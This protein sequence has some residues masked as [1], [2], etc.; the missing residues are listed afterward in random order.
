M[1]LLAAEVVCLPTAAHLGGWPTLIWARDWV[2][3]TV[4]TENASG[5]VCGFAVAEETCWFRLVPSLLFQQW[6]VPPVARRWGRFQGAQERTW[7][8]CR[9]RNRETPCCPVSFWWGHCDDLL[10]LLL[11]SVPWQTIDV[12]GD[13]DHWRRLASAGW[14]A[15]CTVHSKSFCSTS[16]LVF[17]DA[18]KGSTAPSPDC[19][20]RTASQIGCTVGCDAALLQSS[21]L[22]FVPSASA[23]GW[24]SLAS[25]SV[26]IL[27]CFCR[28][29]WIS[30]PF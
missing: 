20:R 5:G 18:F 29:F 15:S 9:S 19:S 6:T 16:L 7:L 21:L 26:G 13:C 17:H 1:L 22:P 30:A 24:L 14:T 25:S 10:R 28:H 8:T 3:E 4:R 11:P 23:R 12:C 27:T 2:A